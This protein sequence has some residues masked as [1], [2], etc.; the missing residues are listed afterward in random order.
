[1]TRRMIRLRTNM[2]SSVAYSGGHL[3]VFRL[4]R[5]RTSAMRLW[6]NTRAGCAMVICQSTGGYTI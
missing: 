3:S 1:M 5:K 6:K 2:I 4:H